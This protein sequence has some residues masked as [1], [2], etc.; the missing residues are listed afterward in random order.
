M[1]S[2]SEKFEEALKT[3]K[4]QGSFDNSKPISLHEAM[5]DAFESCRFRL[6]ENEQ[7]VIGERLKNLSQGF[8][9]D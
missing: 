6:S 1:K 7:K 4:G 3:L 9:W 5:R 2:L 8:I